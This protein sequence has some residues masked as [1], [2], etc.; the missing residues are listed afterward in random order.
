MENVTI[1]ESIVIIVFCIL[2]IILFFKLWGMTNDIKKI[3]DK[4][5]KIKDIHTNIP[6]HEEQNIFKINDLVVEIKTGKQM[7]IK[8]INPDGKYGCYIRGGAVHAGD[9]DESDIEK[10]NKD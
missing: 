1:L 4:Y 3:K 2:Q 8:S 5:L 9:F 10:F 7:R 6:N